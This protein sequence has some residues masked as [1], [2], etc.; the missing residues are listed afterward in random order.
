MEILGTELL[1]Q[2]FAFGVAASLAAA[3]IYSFVAFLIAKVQLLLVS[4]GG[5]TNLSGYWIV[6]F[7]G[8][9]TPERHAIEIF[10]FKSKSSLHRRGVRYRFRYQHFNKKRYFKKPLLGGGFAF[11]R[12]NQIAGVY[13]FD[14]KPVVLGTLLLKMDESTEGRHNPNLFGSY[15][16]HDDQR[17]AQTHK[18]KYVMYKVNLPFWNR[19]RFVLGRSCMKSYEE[20]YDFYLSLDCHRAFGNEIDRQESALESSAQQSASVDTCTSRR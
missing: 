16:E 14:E 12:G 10:R 9:Y 15:Y 8:R 5:N 7:S 1:D 17:I 18:D 3:L 2:N 11:S 19:I 20:A 13:G 4:K 6:F